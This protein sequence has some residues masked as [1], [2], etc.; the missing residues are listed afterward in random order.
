MKAEMTKEKKLNVL[1]VEDNLEDARRIQDLLREALGGQ[2]ACTCAFTVGEAFEQ[3]R[4]LTFDAILLDLNFP[5]GPGLE[6]FRN[7]HA[8]VRM[9]PVLVLASQ[10]DLSL[11]LQAL[12][13]GAQDCLLKPQITGASLERAIRFAMERQRLQTELHDLLLTDSLTG[14]YNRRGFMLLANEQLKLLQRSTQGLLLFLC[15]VDRM[16][17]INNTFGPNRGDQT[18]IDS[19]N[20]L[21]TTFR[22]SDIIAR[23]GND[24]FAILAIGTLPSTEELLQARLQAQLNRHNAQSGRSYQLTF[25]TG[26][27]Y[28]GPGGQTT[29]ER[30]LAMA[31]DQV[32]EQKKLKSDAE[33]K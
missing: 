27:S 2:D 29:I 24:E 32:M 7:I 15:D 4:E 16:K 22:S 14:L 10:E 30:L 18:L 28:V 17:A 3:L 19:A 6:T 26:I 8:Q 9:T 33:A 5:G 21:R 13:I 11:A 20:L 1:L 25:S 23:L 12:R 31:N